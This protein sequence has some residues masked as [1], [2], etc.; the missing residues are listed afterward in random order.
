MPTTTTRAAVQ[1]HRTLFVSDVHLGSPGCRARNLTDFLKRNDCER[2]YLVGDV[3]DG[4]KLKSNFYWTPDHSRVIKAVISK[5]RKGTKVY[6]LAGNH[7][8]FMRQFVRTQLRLGQV[9]IANEVVHTTADGRRLLVTHGDV[10]DDVVNNFPAL[11]FAGDAAYEALMKS[12]EWIN[13]F[14][15]K[16][17]MPY[18]SLSSAVK[19]W[20]KGAVQKISGFDEK[21]IYRCRK[22]GLRGVICGHTHHA[23]VRSLRHGL[24]SYNCGDW[25]ESCTALAEDSAG[26]IRVINYEPAVQAPQRDRARVAERPA[27]VA[28][29]PRWLRD[30]PRQISRRSRRRAA[31]AAAGAEA[32]EGRLEMPSNG[33]RI[34]NGAH[35]GEPLLPGFLAKKPRAGDV[36]VQFSE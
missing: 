28:A 34:H 36:S 19:T 2:L 33:H 8:G 30:L 4:W 16:L 14:R 31:A 13:R 1:K 10:F 22:E 17:G 3:F 6:Y 15:R 11:A 23:E 9:R 18:W 32:E 7:D 12:N 35:V 27:L 25:V 20:V 5:A 29:A 26:R 21:V 24:I